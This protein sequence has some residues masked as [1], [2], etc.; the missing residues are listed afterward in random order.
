[1][2]KTLSS[3]FLLVLVLL[4]ALA[5]GPVY[6]GSG[7]GE[8][9]EKVP[10]F[11][12][13]AEQPGPAE[14]ALVR[15]AGGDIRYTYTLVRAIASSLP[16]EAIQG[17]LN[18][19]NVAYIEPDIEVYLIEHPTGD[20]ELDSGWGV[21]HI[22][23]GTVHGGGNKGAGIKVGVLDTGIDRNHPD[24]NYDPDCSWGTRYGTVEDKHGHG[25]HTAGTVA[26]LDNGKGVVGV[27]PEVTLCIYKVLSDSGGGY[28]SDVIAG[29]QRAEKDGVQ[30]T[31]NSYGSSGDPGATVKAAFDN[32]YAKGVLHVAAAGNSGNKGK[33]S[34]CIYPA[35]WDSLIATAAT[36]SSDNRASFSSTCAEVELAAPGV[37]IRS[38]TNNGGYGTKS[39]TSMASPHVAGTAALVLAANSGWTNS[40]VRVRLQSTADDL[41]DPGR[42]SKYGYGLVDADGAACGGCASPTPNDPPSVSITTPSGVLTFDSG[43]MILFEGMASDNEDGD[44]TANLAWTSSIDGAIGSEG[45]FSKTLSDGNHTITAAVTD[46]GSKTDSESISI[47]VGD[48]PPEVTVTDIETNTMPVGTSESVTI[49]GANFAAGAG[50]TFEGGAG[51]APQATVITVAPNQITATVTVKSGG[52]R[53]DRVWDVRVTNTDVSTGVC[54]GCFTVT[55]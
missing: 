35:R 47:T 25:T 49:T 6:G 46:S 55:P 16:E 34:N 43:A 51:P 14:E 38:T 54:E 11:I 3:G 39:G 5:A 9:S 1:M 23:S 30:V 27:A 28:Y 26:A 21:A 41:G 33:G 13:F 50:V 36:D 15:R 18:N 53:R 8:P 52:P 32:A 19:P 7:G 44:I 29:V 10:V 24:L 45:S 37:S 40:Q 17:L 42:D 2:K 12:G 22:G 31:N 4:T 20:A 48:P